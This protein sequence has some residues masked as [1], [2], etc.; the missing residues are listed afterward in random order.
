MRFLAT[1]FAFALVLPLSVSAQTG[2]TLVSCSPN[3]AV[4]KDGTFAAKEGEPVIFKCTLDNKGTATVSVLLSGERTRENASDQASPVSVSSAVSVPPKGTVVS[5]PFVAVFE[6]GTYQYTITTRNVADGKSFGSALTFTSTLGGSS[7]RF[8]RATFDGRAFASGKDALLTVTI[9]TSSPGT[10][11][12]PF[13]LDAF[14]KGADEK[15]CYFA[16]LASP[17]TRA[18]QTV[19]F[20]PSAIPDDCT[21]TSIGVTLKTKAGFIEDS[22][23]LSLGAESP[24]LIGMLVLLVAAALA[25][26]A[27]T[28]RL[29]RR[30]TKRI[31]L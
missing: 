27:W 30:R 7:A 16:A 14:M 18:T 12:T 19:T 17:V 9:A 23:D 21:A 11:A 31:A 8:T 5:L 28:V 26:L 10:D 1:A 2:V 4:A 25:A 6:S 13:F 3:A 15:A 24:V 29:L 20:S 22:R